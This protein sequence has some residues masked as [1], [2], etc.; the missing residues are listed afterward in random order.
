MAFL[1]HLTD[2][3]LR[4]AGPLIGIVALVATVALP[5]QAAADE[6]FYEP[7]VGR[8]CPVGPSGNSPGGT[9][10][11]GHANSGPSQRDLDRAAEKRAQ[12]AA[13]RQEADQI[14]ARME[15]KHTFEFMI[16]AQLR[17]RDILRR[18][19]AVRDGPNV[20]EAIKQNESNLRV[21]QAALKD[22]KKSE[23]SERN[24]E[25]RKAQSAYEFYRLNADCRLAKLQSCDAAINLTGATSAEIADAYNS[26]GALY[27]N[28]GDYKRAIAD[29]SRSIELDP[30][31]NETLHIVLKNR[32][33]A[34]K[35]LHQYNNAIE[36]MNSVISDVE[37]GIGEKTWDKYSMRAGLYEELGDWTRAIADINSI[38]LLNPVNCCASWIWVRGLAFSEMHDYNHAISDHKQAMSL[39]DEAIR[40]N[41][42][43]VAAI[44]NR[45]TAA[46]DLA[47]ALKAAAQTNPG[48]ETIEGKTVRSAA[49]PQ[50]CAANGSTALGQLQS[51]AGG[52]SVGC[53]VE[54]RA[55]V[56]TPNATVRVPDAHAVMVLSDA[57]L[58]WYN[59]TPAFV[60][61]N[62]NWGEARDA[63]KAAQ[64]RREE[65]DRQIAGAP[66]PAAKSE[67]VIKLADAVVVE[68]AAKG[69]EVIAED[70]RAQVV[71]RLPGPPIIRPSEHK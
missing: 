10:N 4:L 12:Y 9:T 1:N 6:C 26:R 59:K 61:A 50:P 40:R 17:L 30:T 49:A 3:H 29:Y 51:A 41:P 16:N 21:N 14:Y 53:A 32:A 42:A 46:R 22:Y 69:A 60:Q 2:R 58:A 55:D 66:S 19:K 52:G 35:G 57:E 7:G 48:A 23:A 27:S 63:R 8:V 34:Y 5:S 67:L 38:M 56:V 43:D 28:S 15:G 18:Q 37:S 70:K 20:R 36:D 62:S 68:Q 54:N 45:Q 39:F 24:L 33:E 47:Q 64:A 65:L 71:Q 11:G 31:R 13:I 25:R 44:K